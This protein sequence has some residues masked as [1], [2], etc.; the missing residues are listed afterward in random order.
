[1]TDWAK[2]KEDLALENAAKQDK[3]E[4]HV[5]DV[6]ELFKE[7]SPTQVHT[8]VIVT[9][10]R[11]SSHPKLD[12]ALAQGKQTIEDCRKLAEGLD[13]KMREFATIIN[14]AN[15][16]HGFKERVLAGL[17]RA[18]FKKA[19][20]KYEQLR[21]ERVNHM[22]L[23]AAIQ[24]IQNY[25]KD[26]IKGLGETESEHRIALDAYEE[27]INTVLAK[28]EE[29][30]PVYLEAVKKR[31]DLEQKV[32]SIEPTLNTVAQGDR[33]KVEQEYENLKRELEVAQFDE[34]TALATLHEAQ[35]DLPILQ[36]NRDDAA[37]T[38]QAIHAMRQNSLEKFVNFKVL[39]DHATKALRAQARIEEYAAVDP[40]FNAMISAIS[41]NNN[42][43]AGAALEVWA[44][45]AR[46]AAVNPELARQLIEELMVNIEEARNDLLV[47]EGQVTKGERMP[48]LETREKLPVLLKHEQPNSLDKEMEIPMEDEQ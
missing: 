15:T 36:N 40:A 13:L 11:A 37:Q 30:N 48:L 25:T 8:G 41:K 24:Q 4:R 19:D 18:G 42:A 23:S 1:M 46:K 32:K 16:P 43:T 5:V 6:D 28:Q 12:K 38:I 35:R 20:V 22:D 27:N 33:P 14:S 26:T 44:D 45:R 3:K 10:R 31:E 34:K 7:P 2:Y 9:D 47:I 17:G 21:H 29:T 39:L